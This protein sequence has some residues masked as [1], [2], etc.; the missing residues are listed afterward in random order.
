LKTEAE[1]EEQFRAS[2]D[3]R[4]Y[5]DLG[6]RFW[7]QEEWLHIPNNFVCLG[8]PLTGGWGMRNTGFSFTW[9]PVFQ[10]FKGN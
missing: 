5:L 6:N 1:S 3:G 8:G 7:V 4:K 9:V 10:V 2:H